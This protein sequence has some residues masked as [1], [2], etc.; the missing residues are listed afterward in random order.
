MRDNFVITNTDAMNCRKNFFALK[1]EMLLVGA[2]G[3]FLLTN[4]CVT[5]SKEAHRVDLT[6]DPI[7]ANRLIEVSVRIECECKF[8]DDL[9]SFLK[10]S[11]YSDRSIVNYQQASCDAII[12]DM[13]GSHIFRKVVSPGDPN[14]DL[15]IRLV[16]INSKASEKISLS[17]VDPNKQYVIARYDGTATFFAITVHRWKAA[18][19]QTLAD[20][21]K[22]MTSDFLKGKGIGTYRATRYQAMP[23]TL[24]TAL[25]LPTESVA[26]F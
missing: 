7:Q 13:T 5:I 26:P 23:L 3:L 16:N 15:L 2:L 17:V 6:W 22:Q 10:A 24:P 19:R 1:K 11:F 14:Y 18:V 20:I 8:T 12:N 4:G 21:R 25:P 9:F